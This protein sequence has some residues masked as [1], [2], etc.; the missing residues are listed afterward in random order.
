MLLYLFFFFFQA[1]DGIR[2]LTVTGVQT[3]ALPI[4]QGDALALPAG[5]LARVAIEVSGDA[6][7]LGGPPHL[8]LDLLAGRPARLE[9]EGD[10]L[11]HG[12]VRVEGVALEHHGDPPGPRGHVAVHALV[13]DVYLT[14][15]RSL[16]PRD[17]AEQGR[18]PRA[19]GAEQDE[20]LAVA[21][22]QVHPVDGMEI[23][24]VLS[25][26][27]DFDASHRRGASSRASARAPWYPAVL[28]G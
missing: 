12:S 20:E 14:R 24:E 23:P 26:T 21:D 7:H 10:V 25:E 5:E 3:C 15:C 11:E 4:S 18:L 13:P 16:E 22:R 17:H 28:P 6:E 8:L 1:E 19:G 9:R 2:D 27:S